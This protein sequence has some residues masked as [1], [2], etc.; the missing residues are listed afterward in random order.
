[1]T[2]FVI[3]SCAMGNNVKKLKNPPHF[4]KI[5]PRETCVV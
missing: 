3:A 5:L 1:M 2:F 4:C